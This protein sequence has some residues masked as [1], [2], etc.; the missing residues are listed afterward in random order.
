MF[1]IQ[2]RN[3]VRRLFKLDQHARKETK[4]TRKLWKK[5]H[6]RVLKDLEEQVDTIQAQIDAILDQSG[7][8]KLPSK[9]TRT[10]EV[11]SSEEATYWSNILEQLRVLNEQYEEVINRYQSEMRHPEP[12]LSRQDGQ[13]S[14]LNQGTD[15]WNEWRRIH[16][17]II[18]SLTGIYL[19]G[20]FRGINF[21][22]VDL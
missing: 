14:L 5:E 17:D 3:R 7:L 21:R 22:D 10:H 11:L 1:R 2:L 15:S 12:S 9:E 13:I 4:Q 6:Q 19:N 16:P 20:N 8:N 18:P